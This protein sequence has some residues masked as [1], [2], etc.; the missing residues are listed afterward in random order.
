MLLK[1]INNCDCLKFISCDI[2][3]LGKKKI[4]SEYSLV[5]YN[6]KY[7]IVYEYVNLS[8]KKS[9]ICEEVNFIGSCIENE[10]DTYIKDYVLSNAALKGEYANGFMFY[11]KNVI[12]NGISQVNNE[13]IELIKSKEL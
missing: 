13:L 12:I 11:F 2:S 3:A 6:D 8:A 7:Y 4:Y 5:K 9:I 1:D 10:E